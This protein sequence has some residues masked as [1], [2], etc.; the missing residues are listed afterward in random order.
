MT[1]SITP[2]L[3]DVYYFA[4]PYTVRDADG[5]FVPE[6]EEANFQLCCQRSA[7]LIEAGFNIYAPIC[8]THP[9]HR[10]SPSFLA[11]HEHQRWYELDNALMGA[12][13]EEAWDSCVIY[14]KTD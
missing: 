8:H 9:I 13:Y 7:R 14:L 11:V 3:E 12:G 10:A 1:V 2:R 6:A 4:H 5:N